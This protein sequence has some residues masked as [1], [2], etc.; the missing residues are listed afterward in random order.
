VSGHGVYLYD[1]GKH[2]KYQCRCIEGG[3]NRVILKER[4]PEC[5][6]AEAK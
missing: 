4:C 6:K 5:S 2:V 1:C 3:H